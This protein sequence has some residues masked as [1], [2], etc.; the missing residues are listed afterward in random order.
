ML[1]GL[2][3]GGES[4]LNAEQIQYALAQRTQ[5]ILGRGAHKSGGAATIHTTHKA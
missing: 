1:Y 3:S 5:G 4:L 2:L